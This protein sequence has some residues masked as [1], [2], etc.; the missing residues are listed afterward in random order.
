MSDET[1]T[2]QPLIAI[3]QWKARPVAADLGNTE[4]NGNPVVAVGFIID[5]GPSQ[6]RSISWYGY[7]TEKTEERSIESLRH[8]GWHGDMINDLSEIGSDPDL[9]VYLVI[10][11]EPDQNGEVRAKVRWVNAGGGVALKNRMNPGEAMSFAQRMR[12][13]IMSMGAKASGG[14]P[15][16]GGAPAANSGASGQRFADDDIPF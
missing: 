13:K 16:T 9:R 14:R 2:P 10:E 4:L 7:F 3:G 6:G 15:A 12:G 1:Q 11:H 8:C 5:E